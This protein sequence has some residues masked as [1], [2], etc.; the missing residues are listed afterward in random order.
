MSL[1]L[2]HLRNLVRT[3]KAVLALR[4]EVTREL[5]PIID[6]AVPLRRLAESVNDR[7]QVLARTGR[8]ERVAFRQSV[9]SHFAF[10]RD[11]EVRKMAAQLMPESFMTRYVRDKDPGVRAVAAARAPLGQVRE[12][13]RNFPKDDE[14]RAIYNRRRPTKSVLREAEAEEFDI[15]GDEPLGDAGKTMDVE[16]SD[17]FYTELAQRCV[18]DYG[19][20]I[21]RGWEGK[22]VGNLVRAY[23]QTSGVE[24]DGEKL[25]EEIK[26]ILDEKDDLVLDPTK[27]L[28]EGRAFI[29]R[30]L[31]A[32]LRRDAI[33]EA[34]MFPMLESDEVTDPVSD[35]LS[36]RLTPET[37]IKEATRVFRVQSSEIPR[38]IR[39]Y[40]L[41]EGSVSLVP[42]KARLPHGHLRQSDERALD[43]FVEHWNGRQAMAGEPLR[44]KW[45]PDPVFGDSVGFQV[46]LT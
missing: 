15:H 42:M 44:L 45:N 41:G 13:M 20:D 21:E 31:V 28:S 36:A 24:L 2:K 8:M 3:E 38:A 37:Y 25:Q 33:D 7:L 46:S 9:I 23:K 29:L 11:A 30:S 39:K 14:L 27:K 12:M 4:R 10:D 26:E 35:L 17:Q 16:L 22:V 32:D 5:G 1:H 34:P 18:A 40:R 43:R 19:R 6:T